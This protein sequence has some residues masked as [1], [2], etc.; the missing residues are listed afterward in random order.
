MTCHTQPSCTLPTVERQRTAPADNCIGCHMPKRDVRVISHSS[1]TNHRI[2]ARPD[3]P[4]PESDFH[5]TT[6][7]LPDLIHLNPV[8]GSKVDVGAPAQ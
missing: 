2:L 3:E 4:I 5:Q 7:A 8:P 6:A 1:I